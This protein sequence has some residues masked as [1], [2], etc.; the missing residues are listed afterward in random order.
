MA[1]KQCEGISKIF[2]NYTLTWIEP[3]AAPGSL[4]RLILVVFDIQHN[5]GCGGHRLIGLRKPSLVT[6][7][8]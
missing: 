8:V 6:L 2:N 1:Y 3:G 4:K 5:C 7:Y